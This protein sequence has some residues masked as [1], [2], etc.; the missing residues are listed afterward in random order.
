MSEKVARAR[1]ELYNRWMEDPVNPEL[2]EWWTEL[3]PQV[4]DSISELHRRGKTFEQDQIKAVEVDDRKQSLVDEILSQDTINPDLFK[5]KIPRQLGVDA[6]DDMGLVKYNQAGGRDV[7]NDPKALNI[8]MMDDKM[9]Y[10]M[11][12]E[13]MG[14]WSADMQKKGEYEKQGYRLYN[15]S[16]NYVEEPPKK[17]K[18]VLDIVREPYV[19]QWQAWVNTF[20]R[21]NKMRQ[22]TSLMK[23]LFEQIG[24]NPEESIKRMAQLNAE[25]KG[26]PTSEAYAMFNDPTVSWD[27]TLKKIRN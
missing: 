16:K 19:G 25:I 6:P 18:S 5:T 4:Q 1:Y 26:I 13:E 27:E 10:D 17:E 11:N 23:D 3:N 21:A 12:P 20:S 7:V 15:V 24:H 2:N 8:M 14:K 9:P 22:R